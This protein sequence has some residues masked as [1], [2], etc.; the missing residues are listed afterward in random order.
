VGSRSPSTSSRAPPASNNNPKA[1]TPRPIGNNTPV[2]APTLTCTATPGVASAF[3]TTA[4]HRPRSVG[5]TTVWVPVPEAE[6]TQNDCDVGGRGARV[7]EICWVWVSNGPKLRLVTCVWGAPAS[8]ASTS[9][10]GPIATNTAPPPVTALARM[11]RVPSGRAGTQS[12]SLGRA[13]RSAW[14]VSA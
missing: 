1:P 3:M 11:R 13:P 7:P 5:Q 14:E 9:A 12:C 4:D 10:W 2:L 6:A 8:Q